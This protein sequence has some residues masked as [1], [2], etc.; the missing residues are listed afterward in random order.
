LNR[1]NPGRFVRRTC[2]SGQAK[3]PRFPILLIVDIGFFKYTSRPEDDPKA[4]AEVNGPIG[5]ISFILSLVVF[6]SGQLTCF[7]KTR[8]FIHKTLFPTAV[9]PSDGGAHHLLVFPT[10]V[11]TSPCHK[12]NVKL[13]PSEV[14][15]PNH[16][17]RSRCDDRILPTRSRRT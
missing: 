1:G 12:T 13:E 8:F 9:T 10:L 15:T 16:A 14:R 3:F 2:C 6:F 17:V 11:G 7:K 4:G 5:P